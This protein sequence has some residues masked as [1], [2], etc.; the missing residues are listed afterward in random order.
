MKTKTK[1]VLCHSVGGAAGAFCGYVASHGNL[2]AVGAC[3][4]IGVMLGSFAFAL[5]E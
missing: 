3:S 1:I 2:A 4:I 5:L